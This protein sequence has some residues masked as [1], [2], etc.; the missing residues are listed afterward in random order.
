M[1][2]RRRDVY[3]GVVPNGLLS[4]RGILGRGKSQPISGKPA[5]KVARGARTA[6]ILPR[7]GIDGGWCVAGGG[8][9]YYL[10]EGTSWS[11]GLALGN[12]DLEVIELVR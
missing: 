9:V 12:A 2:V 7:S 10:P 1:F 4:L 6:R 5:I 8:W 3:T 11:K